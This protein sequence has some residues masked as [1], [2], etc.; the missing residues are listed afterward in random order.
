MSTQSPYLTFICMLALLIMQSTCHKC[1][2]DFDPNCV[3]CDS[4]GNCLYCAT[5]FYLNQT[6]TSSA[7]CFPC[8]DGCERCDNPERCTLCKQ[9]G[10][11]MDDYFCFKCDFGCKRCLDATVCEQC[12]D[13]YV[14]LGSKCTIFKIQLYAIVF[15]ILVLA[16]LLVVCCIV[17]VKK[18]NRDSSFYVSNA[19][20]LK[21]DKTYN[22]FNVLDDDSK[23]DRTRVNEVTTI[24]QLGRSG[25]SFIENKIGESTVV[26]D[27][28]KLFSNQQKEF[29]QSFR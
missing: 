27:D 9:D 23:R 22:T 19:K 18:R 24:G 26:E 10:Y 2:N 3:F 17:T 28:S 11:Y 6:S 15:C 21:S 8:M 5:G 1:P 20:S 16:I 25:I 7:Y 14:Q 4:V 12:F 13:K 29:M